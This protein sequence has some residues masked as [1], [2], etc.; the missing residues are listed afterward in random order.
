MKYPQFLK[1]YNQKNIIKYNQKDCIGIIAPS[2]GIIEKVKLNRLDNAIKNMEEKGFHII[3]GK[4]IRKCENGRSASVKDRVTEIEEMFLNKNIKYISCVSGGDY[5]KE[6]LPYINYKVIDDNPKWIQGYSDPTGLLYVITTKLD[7][8]T[9]YSNNF[10]SYGMNILHE[11]LENNIKIL[12]GENIVQ[13]TYHKFENGYTDYITGLEEYNL[14]NKS[15]CESLNNNSN[16][17]LKGRI[18]GGCTDVLLDIVNT[19]MDYTKDFLNRYNNENI[20]WYFDNFDI[21]ENNIYEALNT[22]Y[23]AK[24]FKNISCMLF[25]RNTKD[26]DYVTD[27]FKLEVKRFLTNFNIN[28]PV[29][30]DVDIGHKAPQFTIVNGSVVKL[31][32]ENNKIELESVFLN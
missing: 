29:I 1:V 12:C 14:S 17:N 23:K 27:K 15:K 30:L 19:E 24:W 11:S 28:I 18:I 7:I 10:C 20:I 6:I 4:N 5:L 3:E 31:N 26:K 32:Y 21:D 22:L 9:I 25:G 13:K 2:K 16:I 8:A